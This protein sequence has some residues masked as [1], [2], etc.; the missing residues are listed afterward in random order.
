LLPAIRRQQAADVRL[1]EHKLVMEFLVVLLGGP[2]VTAPMNPNGVVYVIDDDVHVRGG[3]ASLIES[4][5]LQVETFETTTEFLTSLRN[6][7]PQCLVL[8]VRLQGLSGLDFQSQ[9]GAANINIPIIFI[10]GHA[11]IPMTVKAM[12]AGAVEFLTKPV[13]E[14]DLLD[15]VQIALD[16]DRRR[17]RKEQ[18][19]AELR[20]RVET[21]TAREREVMTFVTM[22]KMNKQV[23]AEIG[24][25]EI[26]VKVHRHNV[27]KKMGA[28]S[29]PELVR[30][31][32][33]LAITDC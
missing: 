31:A 17:R 32:E 28:K 11:D 19:V 2:T 1:D 24:L 4:V 33:S 9:L 26:T 27:M 5:G 15:A 23:A 6:D 8:D 30:M 18:I 10:T 13:R 3:L 12:K 22:G 16:D 29:L 14:Q 21:L 20:A 25:S 7:V